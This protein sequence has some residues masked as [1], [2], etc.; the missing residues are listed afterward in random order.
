MVKRAEVRTF[1]NRL[2]CDKCETEMEKSNMVLTSHPPQYQ[3]FCN[4]CDF[5]MISWTSYPFQT[6]TT[7]PDSEVIVTD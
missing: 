4:S 2:Y 6:L 5:K 1:I 3:Y 7:L